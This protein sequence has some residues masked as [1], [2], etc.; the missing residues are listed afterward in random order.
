MRYLWMLMLWG[1]CYAT[2]SRAQGE[3]DHAQRPLT[4]THTQVGVGV[5]SLYHTYLSPLRYA[6]HH[7]MLHYTR[8]RPT[9]HDEERVHWQSA[10]RGVVA[11]AESPTQDATSYQ[12]G[13]SYASRWL[14][15][16]QPLPALYLR[17]GVGV[18]GHV[19]GQYNNRNGNNPAM[20]DVA[21]YVPLTVQAHYAWRIGRL[22]IGVHY[23]VDMPLVGAQWAPRYTQSYYEMFGLGRTRGVV[24][25]AWVGNVPSWRQ[26]LH[27]SIPLGHQRISIGLHS[28]IRQHTLRG[29]R[30]H[31]WHHGVSIGYVRQIFTRS[32]KRN[33]RTTLVY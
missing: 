1:L 33:E 29:N 10:W 22:P 6:G 9:R 5:S 19:G 13:L 26:Q 24:A 2:S 30:Q 23:Q 11:K 7:V 14:Y 3:V 28:D 20:A 8:Q 25:M 16:W 15:T 32:A 18:E 4:T 27:L 17:A 12:I 21:L 31:A